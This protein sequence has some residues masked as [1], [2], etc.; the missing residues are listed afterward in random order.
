MVDAFKLDIHPLAKFVAVALA[1]CANNLNLAWP[2]VATLS[3]ATSISTRGVQRWLRHLEGIGA[4]ERVKDAGLNQPITYRLNFTSIPKV[5]QQNRAKG[6][7]QDLRRL[8]IHAFGSVCQYCNQAGMNGF[9]PDGRVWHVDRIVP[10]SRGGAY[11]PSNVTLACATCNLR[12]STREAVTTP[13][14]LSQIE[15]AIRGTR[16]MSTEGVP[17]MA[18]RGA[19]QRKEGCHIAQS[20]VPHVAPNPSL[21]R[22]EPKSVDID[23]SEAKKKATEEV[24]RL[25][26]RLRVTPPPSKRRTQ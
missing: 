17:Y 7:P 4:I 16:F 25:A 15:G 11:E 18:P 22:H 19:T 21:I 20:E 8:V 14:C 26:E 3:N 23:V 9:G 2:S 13:R 1:N 10:G 12:K 5:P 24:R 6:C